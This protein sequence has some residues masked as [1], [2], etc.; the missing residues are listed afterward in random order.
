M[1]I[2]DGEQLR[3]NLLL[4]GYHSYRSTASV[5]GAEQV[6]MWTEG[7]E[8]EPCAEHGSRIWRSHRLVDIC[9]GCPPQMLTGNEAAYELEAVPE[10]GIRQD[11][12]STALGPKP[13]SRIRCGQQ[14]RG[15]LSEGYERTLTRLTMTTTT[16]AKGCLRAHCYY[17]AWHVPENW[18]QSEGQ[19]SEREPDWAL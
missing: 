14:S 17:T 8:Q 6:G 19:P 11:E 16:T 12:Q 3:K 2:V 1:R 9:Q 10:A 7:S 4:D 18:M 5:V 13:R 15:R